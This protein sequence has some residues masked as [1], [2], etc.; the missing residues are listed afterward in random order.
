MGIERAAPRPVWLR[1]C[2]AQ[3]PTDGV[4]PDPQPT[5]DRPDRQALAVEADD[6][7]IALLAAPPSLPLPALSAGHRGGF[8]AGATGSATTGRAAASTSARRRRTASSKAR[9]QFSS[10]CHRS[11]A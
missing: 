10:R 6:L 2:T 8:P 5:P 3:P 7:L 1:R 9:L 4:A 11:A